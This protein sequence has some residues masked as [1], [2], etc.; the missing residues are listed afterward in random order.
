M[1]RKTFTKLVNA[2]MKACKTA[3]EYEG[4]MY[5]PSLDRLNNFKNASLTLMCTPEHALQGFMTKPTV[6][7]QNFTRQLGEGVLVDL[8]EWEE[9]IQ[10]NITYL[11]LLEALVHERHE[12]NS[13]R[14]PATGPRHPQSPKVS[15]TLPGKPDTTEPYWLKPKRP[16]TPEDP[17]M[18]QDAPGI[19]TKVTCSWKEPGKSI[20]DGTIVRIESY[21]NSDEYQETGKYLG[22]LGICVSLQPHPSRAGYWYGKINIA[23]E[24]PEF[25]Q[26]SL[27]VE[28]LDF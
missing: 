21:G 18:S 7:L 20:P 9:K 8:K 4:E 19:P 26:V 3:L 25:A 17:G 22:E 13:R 11:L 6:E 2:R 1:N 16:A 23:D 5:V 24:A 27:S 15:R 10:E 28:D 14:I 12:S